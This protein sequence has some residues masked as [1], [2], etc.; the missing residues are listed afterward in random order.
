MPRIG[1]SQSKSSSVSMATAQ[2]GR[3]DRTAA[4]LMLVK[5]EDFTSLTQDTLARLRAAIIIQLQRRRHTS[6]V[7]AACGV[8]ACYRA[9]HPLA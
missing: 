9:T 6:E 4:G 3:L 1:W 7:G 5:S 8:A 2:I